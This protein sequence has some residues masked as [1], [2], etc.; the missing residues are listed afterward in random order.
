MH[1][2]TRRGSDVSL[3]IPQRRNAVDFANAIHSEPARHRAFPYSMN[4]QRGTHQCATRKCLSD[5][6]DYCAVEDEL[7]VIRFEEIPSQ[8]K[9]ALDAT[10]S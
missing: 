6:L 3:S 9:N 1:A 7:G 5:F 8:D 10:R 4:L 2:Q